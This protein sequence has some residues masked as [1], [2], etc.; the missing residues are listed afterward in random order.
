MDYKDDTHYQEVVSVFSF[1]VFE[2]FLNLYI[3][4]VNSVIDIF[5][6]DMP[7]CYPL[8]NQKE[9]DLFLLNLKL[10]TLSQ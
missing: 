7:D 6:G 3:I 10:S 5:N 9:F 2:Y 1:F 4:T 8:Q